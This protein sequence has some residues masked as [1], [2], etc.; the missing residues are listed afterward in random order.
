VKQHACSLV[1]NEDNAAA[2]GNSTWFDRPVLIQLTFLKFLDCPRT[3]LGPE[4]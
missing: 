2:V 1:L 3:E 4:G